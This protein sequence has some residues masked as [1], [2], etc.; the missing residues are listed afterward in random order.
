MGK[1]KTEGWQ[2]KRE[3][4]YNRI[5]KFDRTSI[6][7]ATEEEIEVM[8]TEV[9]SESEPKISI[10]DEFPSLQ[11][12]DTNAEVEDQITYIC[13]LMLFL[14]GAVI[15]KTCD[16]MSCVW[17]ETVVHA[18]QED[19]NKNDLKTNTPGITPD[20]MIIYDPSNIVIDTSEYDGS[21]YKIKSDQEIY[22][23][24]TVDDPAVEVTGTANDD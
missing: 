4:I 22:N 1:G 9:G 10:N 23:E 21:V 16:V 15:F 12:E 14:C 2:E 7:K 19:D 20:D 13:S 18:L 17:V 6:S 8:E 24:E 5:E 3:K 11:K